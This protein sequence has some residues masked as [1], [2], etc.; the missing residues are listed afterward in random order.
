[1]FTVGLSGLSLA[2]LSH[3]R[4]RRFTL[5]LP[6]LPRALDGLTI[7]HVTDIHVG[8]LTCG[9]AVREMVA[10]TN[11]LRADLVLMTGDLIDY[12]LSDLPEA[13]AAV[14]AMEGRYGLWMIEG[15][16]D[17]ADD[18][19][20]FQRRIKAAGLRL[21]QDA[22]AITQVRGCPVQIFGLRWLRGWRARGAGFDRVTAL[23]LRH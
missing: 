18:A 20:E 11:A 19:G 13:I 8:R 15:N 9:R 5:A 21:L 7:A 4:V 1:M 2:Q 22:S 12:A 14:K 6:A 23:Q 10:K 16:H 17:L 3:L